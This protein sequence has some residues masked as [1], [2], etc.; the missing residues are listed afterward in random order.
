MFVRAYC[1]IKSFYQITLHFCFSL[2]FLKKLPKIQWKNSIV[3][4]SFKGTSEMP[5]S[6]VQ[7]KCH[8]YSTLFR[9]VKSTTLYSS[10]QHVDK[11]LPTA[12]SLTLLIYCGGHGGG[13]CGDEAE[14]LTPSSCVCVDVRGS[15]ETTWVSGVRSYSR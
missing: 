3:F 7:R 8:P 12:Q 15:S 10:S 14:P 1:S 11:K 2:I 9:Q 6:V 13:F 5:T 4:H